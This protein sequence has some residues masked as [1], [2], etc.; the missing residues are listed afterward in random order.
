MERNGSIDGRTDQHDSDT[1]LHYSFKLTTNSNGRCS[2][3]NQAEKERNV[4]TY[5]SGINA[6]EGDV[7]CYCNPGNYY[8]Y[9][10]KSYL[11]FPRKCF[12]FRGRYIYIAPTALQQPHISIN[13]CVYGRINRQPE[14]HRIAREKQHLCSDLVFAIPSTEQL[15]FLPTKLPQYRSRANLNRKKAS[16]VL[17]NQ[18]VKHHTRTRSY[19]YLSNILKLLFPR[20]CRNT[21]VSY[22]ATMTSRNIQRKQFC[23][24]MDILMTS[25]C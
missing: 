22:N 7:S 8:C 3:K 21:K 1:N 23:I 4:T 6:N 2:D 25:M 24:G 5:H 11:I 12:T 9:R 10:L 17:D 15:T 14:E 18:D 13:S 20:E 16:P 19:H